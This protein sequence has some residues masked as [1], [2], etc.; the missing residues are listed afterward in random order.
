MKPDFALQNLIPKKY[1]KSVTVMEFVNATS[2]RKVEPR[3]RQQLASQIVAAEMR[4]IF[5]LGTF[6]PDGHPGNWLVDVDGRRLVRIDY[7]QI[8]QISAE[9]RELMRKILKLMVQPNFSTAD[10]STLAQLLPSIFEVGGH[11]QDWTV[12]LN[13]VLRAPGFPSHRNPHE[14]L[15]YLR[16]ALERR[17][18]AGMTVRFEADLRTVMSALG[19]IAGFR[20][21]M[22]DPS[23]F[24]RLLLTGLGTSRT[25]LAVTTVRNSWENFRN[26]CEILLRSAPKQR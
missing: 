5:E 20:D 22:Q 15:I 23:A 13:S 8:H 18:G 26:S 11:V 14:R 24:D 3:L 12:H 19:R 4:A 1:S 2:L 16:E 6:D 25:Q 17:L 21:F 10:V 9:K 7:A